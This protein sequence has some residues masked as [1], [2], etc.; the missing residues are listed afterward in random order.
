[1]VSMRWNDDLKTLVLAYQNSNIDIVRE[2]M[3]LNLPDIMK[4][5]IPGDKT[6]YDMFFY[7]ENVYLSTGFGIVVLNLAKNEISDTYYIG[8]GGE[9]LRV[10]QV[11]IDGQYIWAA[12]DAGIRRGELSDPFLV[13]YNSWETIA[14]IPGAVGVFQ[15]IAYF[16]GTIFTSWQDPG[17]N[18]DRLYYLQGPVWTEYP[19]FSGK[20]CRELLDQGGFLSLVEDKAVT[21]INKDKLIVQR[22]GI[23]DPRSVSLD[24]NN[25]VWIADDGGGLIT[26]QGGDI[27]SIIP[28]GPQSTIFAD[29]AS[30]GGVLY[31]V[32][33]GVDGSWNNQ[34]NLATLEFYQDNQWNYVTNEDSRDLVDVEVD[35]V[36]P[37]HAFAASWGH[38]VHEYL[39][40]KEVNQYKVGNSTLQTIIPGDY[41]RVGGLAFDRSGNLWITNSNVENP[42]SVLKAD[43]TWKSFRVENK[44]SSYGALSRIIVTQTGSKW[45][46]IPRGNGLFAMDD[47]GTIDDASD[48]IYERVSVV[49]RFGKVITNDVR[50]FAEDRNGNLWLGTNQGI[51]V[52]YSPHRLFTDGSVYAQ[53]IIVPREGEVNPD[54]TIPGDVLLG[55]QIVTCIEVDGAN[56]KWLGTLGGGVYLVSEDGLEEIRHF[57]AL[58]SPL[59]SDNIDAI[60]LDG[61]SGE[62]FFATDKGIISYKGEALSGSSLYDHVVV[63]PNPVR[64]DYT[65]PIAIK[66]LLEQ[67]NVKIQDMGGNLVYETESLGGQAIWDGTNFRGDRVATGVYLIFLSSPDGNLTHVTKLLFIH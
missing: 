32:Q 57:T 2:G 37:G 23:Y 35:P 34:F 65:G 58:N 50:S 61:S 3:I 8:D 30:A 56:R 20:E 16:A 39:D 24:R 54:G 47:N 45:V 36:N 10:N 46:I 4:K 41:V 59:L 40:G 13:D 44:L 67:T 29:L 52:M 60:A 15:S 48:D 64:E 14:D 38:G 51:L 28:D 22:I 63:Y 49:D 9:A 43:G 5:Q 11:T 18:Q 19:Y 33:G 6:I 7:G 25:K 66:G 26:N 21:L 12:T 1:V 55:D 42:I 27:W 53:E 17:G 62:V 31:A